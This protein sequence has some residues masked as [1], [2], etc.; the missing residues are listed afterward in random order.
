MDDDRRG[1]LHK[2][3]PA[4]STPASYF[5]AWDDYLPELYSSAF[6]GHPDLPDWNVVS[7]CNWNSDDEK[8]ILF[9]PEAVPEL[10]IAESYAAFEL[11]TQRFLGVFKGAASVRL[12]VPPHGSRV[13][14]ITPLTEHGS[15][16]IG[17]DLNLSAG[18]EFESFSNGEVTL[19]KEISQKQSTIHILQYERD[20]RDLSIIC[21]KVRNEE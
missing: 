14:R 7:V 15:Y 20:S 6:T 19:R 10:P 9:Y 2:V 1:L 17:T 12:L 21:A 4:Y 8:E 18:M 16:L 3:I 11:K 5:G 13:V